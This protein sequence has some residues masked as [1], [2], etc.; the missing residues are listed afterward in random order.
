M[1]H[2]NLSVING[3]KIEAVNTAN[4]RDYT[5]RDNKK[6][7]NNLAAD[8]YMLL[9]L[10][11]KLHNSLEISKIIE[12]FTQEIA[13]ILSLDN[14]IYHQPRHANRAFDNKGRHMVTYRL[15]SNLQ[16]LGEIALL[17]RRRFTQE[18]QTFIE[19]ILVTL[20]APLTNAIAYQQ[21]IETALHDPLTGVYNRLS[22]ET[23]FER[24]IEVA[25]RNQS[26]L[27]LISLDIDFFKKVNDTYGHS[28]GD[29]VLKHLTNAVN[30]CIRGSDMF[31]RYGG[32]EFSILLGNTDE[33]GALLLAERIRQHVADSPCRIKGE[34]I[35]ITVSVGVSTYRQSDTQQS[36]AERAD[37]ALYAAKTN[38][39]D[40]VI[41]M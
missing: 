14:I 22:M 32:E 12:T 27:S 1:T 7:I 29:C 21:A 39:R 38:G 25:R 34:K 30:N 35:S 33:E 9:R 18:E 28:A 31:F 2:P 23:H 40:R 11:N 26:P 5:N 17:R 19:K 8:D 4:S 3:S 13:P 24:E 36:L 6:V 41:M 37:Q 15:V 16:P 20:L 10:S